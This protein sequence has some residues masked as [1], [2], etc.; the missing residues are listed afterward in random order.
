MIC[1]RFKFIMAVT[2]KSGVFWV[3]NPRSVVEVYE[4]SSEKIGSLSSR[5]GSVEWCTVIYIPL[6]NCVSK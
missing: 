1:M 2:I 3:V 5:H 4:C 6:Q